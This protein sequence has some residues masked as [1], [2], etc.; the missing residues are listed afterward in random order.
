MVETSCAAAT[1]SSPA[2]TAL[3]RAPPPPSPAVTTPTSPASAPL[4]RRTSSPLSPRPC[5]SPGSS[6]PPSSPVL[7]MWE[8]TPGEEYYMSLRHRATSPCVSLST[9]Q[10]GMWWQLIR[11]QFTGELCN[12]Y[13]ILTNI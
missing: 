12:S 10:E 1:T 3:T 6:T 11:V 13:F 4:Q 8:L 9:R 7:M 2:A 5:L